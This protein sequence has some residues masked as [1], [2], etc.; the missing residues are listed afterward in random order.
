MKKYLPKR[1]QLLSR[2][3]KIILCL[4]A[5]GL[6]LSLTV[7]FYSNQNS[8][9]TH[10]PKSTLASTVKPKLTPAG[11][12]VDFGSRQ[13][14]A[15]PI[16]SRFLGVGGIGIGTALNHAGSYVPQAG[17]HLTKLGDYNYLAE[18]FPTATSLTDASQQ[19]WTLFDS[20]MALTAN[21]DLQ[22][23]IT[24]GYTPT[25]LQPQNQQGLC[26]LRKRQRQDG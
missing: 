12:T 25:W 20:Q 23:I 16:P 3:K 18:I 11:V 1:F 2:G 26:V 6:V 14:K 9:Q 21:Y 15:Y 4:L 8:S 22:P 24:I 5:L 7:L 13:N 10:R 17:F 19:N